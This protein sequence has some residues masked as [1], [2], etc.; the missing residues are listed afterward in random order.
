[1]RSFY[2]IIAALLSIVFHT[3]QSAPKDFELIVAPSINTTIDATVT[4]LVRATYYNAVLAQTNSEP[5]ITA[6]GYRIDLSNPRKHRFV[7]LSRDLIRPTEWHTESSGYDNNA[8]FAFGDTILVTGSDEFFGYYIVADS[9][10]KRYNGKNRIDF[11]VTKPYIE[12]ESGMEIEI[13]KV[14]I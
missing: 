5:H 8:P 2:L 7:A 6:C 4:R 3:P 1:M 13:Q 14:N 10:N 9:M 11:L 12:F